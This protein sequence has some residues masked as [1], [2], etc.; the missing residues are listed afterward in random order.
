MRDMSLFIGK[1]I[2]LEYCIDGDDE[3]DNFI[4]IY[5]IKSITHRSEDLYLVEFLEEKGSHT[6]T[7]FQLAYG[8]G[9]YQGI[10]NY[11]NF[12]II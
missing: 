12:N 2:A 3:K 4:E 5:T 9:I 10:F 7:E 11:K 8:R 1:K 6:L